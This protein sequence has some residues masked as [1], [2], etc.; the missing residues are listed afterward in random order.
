M[1]LD[2]LIVGQGLAGSLLARELIKLR[3]TVCIFDKPFCRTTSSSIA[4]GIMHPITGRRIVKSWMA[5][6]LIPYAIEEY[7]K[8]NPLLFHR[9]PI[10]EIFTSAQQRNE[11]MNKS[12]EP[13]LSN[14]IGETV[15]SGENKDG[16]QLP[17]GGI[18]IKNTGWLNVKKLLVHLR[19][20][21]ILNSQFACDEFIADEIIFE[22]DH[23]SFRGVKVKKII[24][25]DGYYG[26]SNKFFNYLPFVP[27][28]GEIVTIKCDGLKKDTIINRGIYVIPTG[29]GLFRVGATF[30][31]KNLTEEITTAGRES[32]LSSFEKI[33]SLPYTVVNQVAA[34]RP[35]NKDRR[36]FIG[37]HPHQPQIGVFNGL[38]TKGVMLA[39]WFAKHFAEHLV[40]GN[41]LM[42]EVAIERIKQ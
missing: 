10:L 32:L 26:A 3:A 18:Y 20:D 42:P 41:S 31:W 7:D 4:A 12:A 19:R 29:S 37:L 38:G 30:D 11:W 28:K 14:W 9:R 16:I 39:P 21:F 27:A 22:S 13:S 2:F 35:A 1:T 36:P 17:F 6:K 15:S 40:N 34:I 23:V 24:F 33:T 25:C 5:D 8:I